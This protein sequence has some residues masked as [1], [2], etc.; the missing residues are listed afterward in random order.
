[1]W[2][3]MAGSWV[4]DD[5]PYFV[6]GISYRIKPGPMP[7]SEEL[8]DAILAVSAGREIGENLRFQLEMARINVVSDAKETIDA[9]SAP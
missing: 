4:D 6:E 8:A 2:S 5:K 1:M 7:T 9:T 3:T